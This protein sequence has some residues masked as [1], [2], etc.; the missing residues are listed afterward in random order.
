MLFADAFVTESCSVSQPLRQH[1]AQQQ[2]DQ[3]LACWRCPAE[4]SSPPKSRTQSLWVSPVTHTPGQG[5]S[6]MWQLRLFPWK[7]Y[8]MLF[9]NANVT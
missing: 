5:G 8:P 9:A 6:E 7:E 2:S 4:P 1:S 3:P